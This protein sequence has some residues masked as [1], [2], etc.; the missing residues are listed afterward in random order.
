MF[1]VE[2][3]GQIKV[4]KFGDAI[5]AKIKELLSQAEKEMQVFF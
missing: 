4:D 3:F 5:I 2:G 1:T